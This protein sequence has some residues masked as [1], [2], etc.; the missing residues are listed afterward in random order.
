MTLDRTS[1]DDAL[2]ARFRRIAEE[3]RQL[4]S[5]I[6]KISNFHARGIILGDVKN[7]KYPV[8]EEICDGPSH[9][10]KSL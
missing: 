5:P 6:A 2:V 4:P 3:R 8:G 1:G 9:T 10:W 7:V